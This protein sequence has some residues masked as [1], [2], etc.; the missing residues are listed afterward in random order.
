MKIIV[1]DSNKMILGCAPVINERADKNVFVLKRTP[2]DNCPKHQSLT[3][4]TVF[5]V[6]PSD[7]PLPPPKIGGSGWCYDPDSGFFKP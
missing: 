3:G 1:K 4:R 5:E 2:S 7:L 6:N